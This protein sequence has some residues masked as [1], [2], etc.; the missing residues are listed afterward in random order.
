MQL[1]GEELN[2]RRQFDR[3][4]NGAGKDRRMEIDEDFEDFFQDDFKI[5]EELDFK[6]PDSKSKS[7]DSH[8]AFNTGNQFEANNYENR[9]NDFGLESEMFEDEFECD[10]DSLIHE[11][12]TKQDQITTKQEDQ[13]NLQ[14]EGKFSL[15]QTSVY[16]LF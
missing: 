16:Q 4:K 13:I 3:K 9:S 12:T 5:D 8:I 7:E 10:D 2:T 1:L 11:I 6:L 14:F 15:N